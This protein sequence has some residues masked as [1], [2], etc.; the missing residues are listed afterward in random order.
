MIVALYSYGPIQVFCPLANP[1]PC[2]VDCVVGEW[3]EWSACPPP[4]SKE[5]GTKPSFRVHKTRKLTLPEHGGKDCP[6]DKE[7]KTLSKEHCPL[8]TD[9]PTPTTMQIIN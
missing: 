6:D 7:W 4:C 3:S 8:C 9:S 2:P 5:R 1:K